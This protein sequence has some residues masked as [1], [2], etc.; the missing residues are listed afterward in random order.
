[1]RRLAFARD[2]WLDPEELAYPA[3]SLRRSGREFAAIH[4]ITGKLVRGICSIPDTYF[5]IPARTT[6]REHGFLSHHQDYTGEEPDYLMFHP[7]T[8]RRTHGPE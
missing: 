4:A 5:S 2:T 3:G 1:M 8:A 6:R 7:R